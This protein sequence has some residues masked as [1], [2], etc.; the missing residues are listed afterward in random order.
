M[1]EITN[2]YEGFQ[3]VVPYKVRK[4]LNLD[5]DHVLEWNINGKEKVEVVFRKKTKFMDLKGMIN[6]E[7]SIDSVSLQRKIRKGEEIDFS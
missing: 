3:T 5:L 7:D 2:L 1:G 4:K 6:S